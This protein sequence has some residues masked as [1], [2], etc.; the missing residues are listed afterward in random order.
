MKQKVRSKKELTE[1][2]KLIIHFTYVLLIQLG[3]LSCFP[4]LVIF[5][6]ISRKKLYLGNYN[7]I[8]RRD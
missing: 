8:F 2:P 4:V 3:N 5:L 7:S 6:D 1:K